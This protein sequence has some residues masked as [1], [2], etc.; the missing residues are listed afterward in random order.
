MRGNKGGWELCNW[1][2]AIKQMLYTVEVSSV[3]WGHYIK[4]LTT[5]TV[6]N[7]MEA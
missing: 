7:K 4:V 1:E 6:T 2:E 3:V 5:I